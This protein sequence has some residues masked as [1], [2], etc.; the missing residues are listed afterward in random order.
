MAKDDTGASRTVANNRRA[1]FDYFI[2][3]K[4]EAGIALLGSEVKSLREA[5]VQIADS[6][7]SSP[8]VRELV[9]GAA[10]ANITP[11]VLHRCGTPSASLPA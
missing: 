10:A 11:R 7:Y 6:I 8:A 4:F 5:Q 1:R 9:R 2:D 3:E